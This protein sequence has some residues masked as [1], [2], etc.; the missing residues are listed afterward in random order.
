MKLQ[1]DR[2]AFWLVDYE[3]PHNAAAYSHGFKVILGP[4]HT[5]IEVYDLI[6]DRKEQNNLIKSLDP[7][8]WANAANESRK[9]LIDVSSIN[10][11]EG[12]RRFL[13]SV[14]PPLADFS[15]Y[16]NMANFLHLETHFGAKHWHNSKNLELVPVLPGASVGKC[17]VPLASQVPMLPFGLANDR[18]RCS[19]SPLNYY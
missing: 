7:A 3:H 2:V 1:R 9:L 17:S 16:G 5:P 12:L 11:E 8:I 19:A 14:V 15:K 13:K 10:R 18:Y 6:A 4:D